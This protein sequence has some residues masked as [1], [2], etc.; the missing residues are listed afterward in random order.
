M[1][2][3]REIG[4]PDIVNLFGGQHDEFTLFG[5]MATSAVSVFQEMLD[6]LCD[7]VEGAGVSTAARIDQVFDVLT[8]SAGLI[9]SVLTPREAFMRMAVSDSEL[10]CMN[11][12]RGL[13]AIA[14]GTAALNFLRTSLIGRPVDQ[15]VH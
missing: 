6:Q 4:R 7:E 10:L 9:R 13:V 15:L 3:A 2:K 5:L 1:D 12:A 11:E 14:L 8:L